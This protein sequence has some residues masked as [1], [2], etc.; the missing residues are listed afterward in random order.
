VGLLLWGL[1]EDA[2]E[3]HRRFVNDQQGERQDVVRG[4]LDWLQNLLP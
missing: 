4:V 3:V 1:H 2:R